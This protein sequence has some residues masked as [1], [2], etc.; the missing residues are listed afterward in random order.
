MGSV[1]GGS[2]TGSGMTLFRLLL[3]APFL[4]VD[5]GVRWTTREAKQVMTR[6]VTGGTRPAAGAQSAAGLSPSRSSLRQSSK[7]AASH[8]ELFL[9][10]PLYPA[11]FSITF[12]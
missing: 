10:P 6:A 3:L 12:S 2:V 4:A 11:S 8:Q 5:T 9:E 1:T 7:R